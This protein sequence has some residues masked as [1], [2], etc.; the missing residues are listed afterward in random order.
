MSLFQKKAANVE[1]Q[2]L[3][4]VTDEQLTQVTGGSLLSN[5]TN[6]G[7]LD[8]AT[9]TTSGLLSGVTPAVGGLVPAVGGLIPQVG[10]GA[11]IDK[12]GIYLGADVSR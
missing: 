11:S 3:Q 8:T 10:I 6:G 7:L 1:E 2:V 12:S 5:V 4:D 9:S